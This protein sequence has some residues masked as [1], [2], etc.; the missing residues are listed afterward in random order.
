[1]Q[2]TQRY[3]NFFVAD[4][5]AICQVSV[6]VSA[7]CDKHIGTWLSGSDSIVNVTQTGNS[8]TR[9]TKDEAAAKDGSGE[10]KWKRGKWSSP[11]EFMLT[12]I[13]FSVGLGN[14][15]RFPYLCYKNGGGRLA[16]VIDSDSFSLIR[17][18]SL[19]GSIFKRNA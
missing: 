8:V 12:C 17:Q 9:S 4:V 13:G 16:R 14:V 7:M 3:T 15:W 11:R 18:S 1:M 19:T 6:A 2:S 10:Q 5:G